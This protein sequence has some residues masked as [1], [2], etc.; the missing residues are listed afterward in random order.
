V[1]WLG[2]YTPI[3]VRTLSRDKI[4]LLTMKTGF[5]LSFSPYLWDLG[6]EC[7]RITDLLE[8]KSNAAHRALSTAQ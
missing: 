6:T 5:E 3:G 2:E 4:P 8:V 7:T 1:S